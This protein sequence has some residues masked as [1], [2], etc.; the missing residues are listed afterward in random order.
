ME[1][2]SAVRRREDPTATGAGA[3]EGS[4]EGCWNL[5][6]G[7]KREHWPEEMEAAVWVCRVWPQGGALPCLHLAA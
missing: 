4:E 6:R 2:R 5:P 3:K 7:S 1:G